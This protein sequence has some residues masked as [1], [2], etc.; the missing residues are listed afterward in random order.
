MTDTKTLV[1]EFL[2]KLGVMYSG[3][4]IP[5]SQSRNRKKVKLIEKQLNWK[6]NISR[7][8]HKLKTDY[9]QGIAYCPSYQQGPMSVHTAEALDWE[10]E[11]GRHYE[12]NKEIELPALEDVMYSLVQDYSVLDHPTF[13]SWAI[14]YGYDPDSKGAEKIYNA[15][16]DN[17]LMLRI[18]FGDDN[19][20][21]LQEL[22]QDY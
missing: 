12:K 15:C 10:V 4:F 1:H 21:I 7:G 13:E 6:V 2:K 19:V 3:T 11:N 5:H 17:A 20:K 14:E 9:S 8:P 22:F 18:L 16:K